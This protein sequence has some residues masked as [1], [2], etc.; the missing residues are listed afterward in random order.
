MK[1]YIYIIA[2]FFMA[3]SCSNDDDNN[4]INSSNFYGL[5]IGNTW[6]YQFNDLQGTWN[7]NMQTV[8]ITGVQTISGEDYFVKESETTFD[9]GSPNEI[10]IEYVREDA[11]GYLINSFGTILA[12]PNDFNFRGDSYSYFIENEEFVYRT[13][14]NSSN[15]IDTV[16]AGTFIDCFNIALISFNVQNQV[17]VGSGQAEFIYAPDI[18]LIKEKQAFFGWRTF[19]L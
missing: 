6:T 15:I 3:V 8:T 18:G 17:R 14:L 13:F 9:D 19:C 10:T 11:Q 7:E 12:H 5:G 4:T 16:P 2:L 1:K